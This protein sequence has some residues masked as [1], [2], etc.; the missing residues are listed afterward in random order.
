MWDERRP[1][2][3]GAVHRRKS[4]FSLSGPLSPT[5]QQ[6]EFPLRYIGMQTSWYT[7]FVA[8]DKV[9]DVHCYIHG[10]L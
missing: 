2:S 5:K 8:K 3:A 1:A 9:T 7:R 6:S 10:H 4:S